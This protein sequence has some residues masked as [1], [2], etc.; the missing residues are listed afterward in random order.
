[1]RS[2]GFGAGGD[3]GLADGGEV[4]LAEP[5]EVEAVGDGEGEVG[6]AVVVAILVYLVF[7]NLK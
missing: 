6:V 3:E 2:L 5:V 7:G 1:M 4:V